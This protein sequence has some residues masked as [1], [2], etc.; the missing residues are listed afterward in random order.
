MCV[1]VALET[2]GEAGGG[3]DLTKVLLR[4]GIFL[5]R[6]RVEGSKKLRSVTAPA[7][8]V[9]AYELAHDVTL[10][11]RHEVVFSADEAII[12][13]ADGHPHQ[14]RVLREQ[15]GEIEWV[16]DYAHNT[17]Y[18]SWIELVVF[19]FDNPQSTVAPFGVLVDDTL[20]Q[21]EKMKENKISQLCFAWFYICTS[22]IDALTTAKI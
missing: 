5:C 20:L 22:G 15:F 13:G 16:D 11:R 1:R 6:G 7:F 10:G 9:A 2:L 8:F 19:V 12:V 21:L 3:V 4:R 18:R 14:P 17:R